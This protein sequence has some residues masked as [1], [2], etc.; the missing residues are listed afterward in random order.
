LA[1]QLHAQLTPTRIAV[2]M[3]SS[4]RTMTFG[5]LDDR[6]ARFARALLQRGLA[7]GDRMAIVMEN[8]PEFFIAVWAARRAGLRFVP[9]NWHLNATEVA[10]VID[11]SDSRAVV[12]SESLLALVAGALDG[13]QAIRA[14]IIAGRAQ[15]GFE[16][17]NDVISGSTPL[18]ESESREGGFMAYSSGTS[19]RPKGILR[20]L[21]DIPFGRPIPFEHLMANHYGFDPGTVYLSPAP[22][23]HTGPLGWSMGTQ[24]LGGQVILM[25][26]FDAE[27]AL[28]AI[29]RFGVTR[30]QFVPTHFIRMLKLP[31]EVRTDYDLSSLR[32]A[33][34][35]AAPCPVRIKEQMIEWW[36]PIIHEYYGA[37]EGGGFVGLDTAE[38]RA[39]PGSVGRILDPLGSHAGV[40][41]ASHTI[42]IVDPETGEEAAPGSIGVIYFENALRFEYHKDPGQTAEFFNAAGWGTPG[43]MGFLDPD[44]YLYLTDRKSHMIISG[45]VNIYPQEVEAALILHPAVTDVAVIGV[46]NEEF[47]EEVKAVVQPVGEATESL[48]AEL[49][50]YCRAE[51]AGFKCPRTIDFVGQLPRLPNGKLLKR[52]LR[53]RYWPPGEKRI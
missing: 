1:I 33:I 15:G 2:S 5:E 34:H 11:N 22:L 36:G 43:D 47:G 50:E 3:T 40:R 46:P 49:L 39:H 29:E 28:D 4:D 51:L 6:S 35:S 42:R 38:W 52:L 37:S 24:A 17:L 45:G 16:A 32:M 53:D 44:G 25:D 14:R 27:G 30:A 9:V 41:A 12:T 8:C 26:R 19:G 48:R 21:A 31:E 23:Y 20:P 18:S 10:Y 7:V 13:A